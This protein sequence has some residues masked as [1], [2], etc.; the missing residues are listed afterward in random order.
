VASLGTPR[1]ELVAATVAHLDAELESAVELG[2]LLGAEVPDGWPPGEYDRPAIEFFR[3]RLA[4]APEA[5]G[6]YTWYAVLLRP[7]AEHPK[8]VGAGGFFG[9]PGPDGI[10]ELGYSIVPAFRS[11]GLATELVNALV[12]RSFSYPEVARLIAHTREDN[13]ASVRVLERVGFL[14]LGPGLEP[15]TVQYALSRPTA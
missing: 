7:H 10:V 3:A 6:W 12:T 8:L 4:E 5:L 1:L 11:R 9:P 14:L 13:A 15:G 2:R